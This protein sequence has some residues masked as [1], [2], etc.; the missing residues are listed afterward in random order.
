MSTPIS[1]QFGF[2][3]DC[4]YR[5]IAP[6]AE[7]RGALVLVPPAAEEKKAAHRALVEATRAW[8]AA[9]WDCLHLDLR[10]TGDSAGAHAAAGWQTWLDDVAAA[11]A[12]QRA[13]YPDLPLTLVGLRLGATLAA[14]A[15][16][17]APVDHL[18]LLEPFT[19]GPAYLRQCRQRSALRAQLT[20]EEADAAPAPAPGAPAPGTPAAD[21]AAG[22]DFDGFAYSA[23]LVGPL[24]SV[25]LL[26]SPPSAPRVTILQVSGSSRLRRPLSQLQAASQAAGAEVSLANVAVEAFWA[27]IGL[28]DTAPVT[29]AVSAELRPA[30][31]A[32]PPAPAT[33]APSLDLP[34]GARAEVRDFVS[35]E[36][37]VWGVLY[38]PAGPPRGAALLLHGWSGYR[39]GPGALLRNAARAFA[40]AGVAAYSFDFRGRGD[41]EWAVAEASLNSMIRDAS[42]ALPLVLE[43]SGAPRAV[44]LGLCSG[45]E[46]AIGASLAEPAPVGLALWSAPIFSGNFDFARRSRRSRQA[47][48]DYAR[49]LLRGETWAKLFSGRLNWRLIGRA[50][51]GGRSAEDA[52]VAD[53]APDTDTQMREFAA[54][55]GGLLFVYGANDPETE[56]SRAFYQEFCTREG[57]PAA[58]QEVAGA[59]H[60][61]YSRAWHDEVIGATLGWLE[62]ELS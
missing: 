37:R 47:A 55:A 44:L 30:A 18:V 20:A 14:A 8:A 51:S 7:V 2:A 56:P 58:W 10:G 35:G 54:F 28:V 15:A 43:W 9:G 6:A 60:N 16:T 17:A 48:G 50:L 3:H 36:Q 12:F 5:L 26:A 53:R 59:N 40:A 24:A 39:L 34:G 62:Q 38:H 31:A 11:L 49:K 46:V 21:T 52:G 27:A 57:R 4:L 32:Q 61:F 41:S 23:D 25:D 22:F 13:R 42:R 45:A 1:E 29:A 19:D 33:L